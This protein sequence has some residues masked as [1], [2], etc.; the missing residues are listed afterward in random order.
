MMQV[1][2]ERAEPGFVEAVIGNKL[3]HGFGK[4]SKELSLRQT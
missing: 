3:S 2:T 4:S 1:S